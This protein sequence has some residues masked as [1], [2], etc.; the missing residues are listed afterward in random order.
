[1]IDNMSFK[2]VHE[3]EYTCDGDAHTLK[4]DRRDLPLASFHYVALL[5]GQGVS[6]ASCFLLSSNGF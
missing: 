6:G 4:E 2:S 5:H 1:M 3:H